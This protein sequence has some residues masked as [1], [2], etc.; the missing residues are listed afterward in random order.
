MSAGKG[1]EGGTWSSCAVKQLQLYQTHRQCQAVEVW[2][3]GGVWQHQGL[4]PQR[5]GRG[6]NGMC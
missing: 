6:D 3:E 2:E 4:V 5:G 1:E